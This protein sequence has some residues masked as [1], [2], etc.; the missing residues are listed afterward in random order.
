MSSIYMFCSSDVALA[1]C[2]QL[3]TVFHLKLLPFLAILPAYL[4]ELVVSVRFHLNILEGS[5]TVNVFVPLNFQVRV[6]ALGY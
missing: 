2:E 1:F 5:L 4:Q 6:R 3:Q